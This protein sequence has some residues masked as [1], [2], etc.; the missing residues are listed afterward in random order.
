[1]QRNGLSRFYHVAITRCTETLVISSSV[2]MARKF[3]YKIGARVTSGHGAIAATIASQF[4]DELGPGAPAAK[5]GSVWA[6]SGY[7]E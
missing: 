6:E 1:M 5:R 4:I 2:R 7:A 3:A